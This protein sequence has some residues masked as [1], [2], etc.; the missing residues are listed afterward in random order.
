MRALKRRLDR[1]L[2]AQAV[3]IFAVTAAVT[4]LLRPDEH[5]AWWVLKGVLYTSIAMA[6]VVAQR[7]KA[8]RAAGT[9]PRKVADLHRGIRHRE[10]PRDP[11]ERASMRRLVAAQLGQMERGTR[12]L[13]YWLGVMG[14]IAVGTL[15]VGTATGSMTV[16]LILAAGVLAFCCWVLWM[17]HVSMDRFRYMHSVLRTHRTPASAD[18]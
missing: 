4:V 10:V 2:I 18:R 12:W 16:P 1:S 11:E 6:F 14:L 7:R 5:P 17:R 3:L 15:L 9:D 8:G 13:P